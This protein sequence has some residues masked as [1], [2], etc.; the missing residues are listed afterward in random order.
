MRYAHDCDRCKP[1]GEFGGDDL[2][3]CKQGG[4]MDTVIARHSSIGSDYAS[5][6]CFADVHPALGEAKKRAIKLGYLTE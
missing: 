3:F 6:L 2:Y 4:G 1:L 5:G